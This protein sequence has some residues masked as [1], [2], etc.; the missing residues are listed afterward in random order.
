MSEKDYIWT[1]SNVIKNQSRQIANQK[2]IIRLYKQIRNWVIII[3]VVV[4]VGLLIFY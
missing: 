4:I 3:S 1:Q 2:D